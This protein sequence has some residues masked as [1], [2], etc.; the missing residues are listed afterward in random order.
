MGLERSA[1]AFF[2]YCREALEMHQRIYR[3]HDRPVV[4]WKYGKVPVPLVHWKKQEALPRSFPRGPVA[5]S[6]DQSD[7]LLYS[8]QSQLG[9]YCD[10][11]GKRRRRGEGL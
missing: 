9:D 3:G 11:D 8:I 6:K 4:A 5:M 2:P 7:P 1:E 10:R